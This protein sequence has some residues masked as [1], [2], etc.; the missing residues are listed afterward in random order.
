MIAYAQVYDCLRS[1]EK[2]RDS[3]QI[4][5]PAF[6]IKCLGDLW[7]HEGMSWMFHRSPHPAARQ[8][9]MCKPN[10]EESYLADVGSPAL[11][12]AF[13]VTFDHNW[14]QVCNHHCFPAIWGHRWNNF[15]HFHG[16]GARTW[17]R[18]DLFGSQ[19]DTASS[20]VYFVQVPH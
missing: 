20:L 19:K 2:K 16:A 5:R 3:Q 12:F 11:V 14:P 8:N 10:D 6:Q 7:F 4:A 13:S 15:S 18:E 17:K 9:Q 1:A